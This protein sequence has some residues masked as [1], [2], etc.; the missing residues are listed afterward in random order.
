MDTF[1]EVCWKNKLGLREFE[2]VRK[3]FVK[4][5]EEK[6]NPDKTTIELSDLFDYFN[7]TGEEL[8]ELSKK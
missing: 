7:I 1:K 2:I 6:Y 3:A 5:I 8:K 4:F